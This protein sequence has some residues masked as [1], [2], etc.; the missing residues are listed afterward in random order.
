MD[1]ELIKPINK[2]YTPVQQILTS[3]GIP[4]DDIEH[5]LNV[6]EQD[7][8]SPL[9]LKNIKRAVTILVKHIKDPNGKIHIQ[10]DS[11]CDGYTSSSLLLNF[12]HALFPSAIDKFTY[13]F[14]NGKIHGINVD[15]IPEGT[16]LV[17]APDSS[18][19][20]YDIHKEL[21]QKGIDVLVIDHHQADRESEYACV[22]NNQLCDYPTKSLSGVGVVYKVC[23]YIDQLCGTNHAN[24]FLDIVAVGLI[25]DMMDLRYFE[26]HY[27][28]QEGLK[29]IR[30]P[31]IKEMYKKNERKL[32]S[33]L[34]PIGVAFY[35][36]PFIN[37][38]TRVGTQE[39]KQLLFESMLEWKSY[40]VLPSTKRG[41][42][43]GDTETRVGQTVRICTN[44]KSRQDRLRD[45]NVE[46]IEAI[47]KKKNLLDNKVLF[48]KLDDLSID[49]GITGLIAN[50]LS[51]KYK[52]PVAILNKVTKDGKVAWEGS[53]R[54]YERSKLADFKSFLR[55]SQLVYLAEG[56]PNA[57]GIGVYEDDFNTLVE[58][59]NEA[60]KDI[61]FSINYKVDFIYSVHEVTYSNVYDIGSLRTLWGQNVEEPLIVIENI[62]VTKNMIQ[63]MGSGTLKLSLP[64][65]I[66]C[67]KFNISE[68]EFNELYSENGCVVI[69]LIG[70]CNLNEYYG[71]VTPQIKIENYEIV[72]KQDYYF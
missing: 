69:T 5:Y 2:D 67:I 45:S 70:R 28:V 18:S 11:D 25:G 63:L 49:K 62:A 56:H 39:E 41:H 71:R 57:F 9:L 24:K 60:L 29:V 21:Y 23:Q 36:V 50:E 4:F 17:V 7:N 64:G 72:A 47:I 53:G 3:R 54:G 43:N 51:S 30:N 40:D 8:L 48:V 44:I 27:F 46:T 35:I 22:V 33:Q 42:K 65:G 37:S 59:S 52:R 58:Y 6:S 20:D 61:D 1:Y 10:V 34:T 19:N 31:F 26:T 16:T 14:H 68:D 66:D 13:S 38:V 12:I 15:L 55:E 32:G